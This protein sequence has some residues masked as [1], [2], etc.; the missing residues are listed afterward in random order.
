MVF[1]EEENYMVEE[2]LKRIGVKEG[3]ATPYSGLTITDNNGNQIII[4]TFL[5]TADDN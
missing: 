5:K 4:T 3:Y 2:N 1:T